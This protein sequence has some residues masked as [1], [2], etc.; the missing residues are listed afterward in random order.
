[1]SKQTAAEASDRLSGRL[2]LRPK[3]G[4][5]TARILRERVVSGMYGPGK[6][7]RIDELADS[8]GVSTMPVR[9]AL[10]TLAA[11][12]LVEGHPHRGF[13]V[14]AISENDVLDLFSV[15][16]F[17]ASEL[18]R[19]ATGL[20]SDSD[21][22][23]LRAIQREIERAAGSRTLSISSRLN[24]IEDKNFE[25]H[26]T[27]N[28]LVDARRLRWFLRTATRFIPRQFYEISGWLALTLSDH[29]PIILALEAKDRAVAAQLMSDHILAGGRLVAEKMRQTGF[30]ADNDAQPTIAT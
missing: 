18:A 25:F 19:R 30:W 12:G 29:P 22:A 14:G 6:R 28:R 16:A 3:I 20:I 2:S 24:L 27:I 9:E 10:I 17:C 1:M 5:E 21:V 11:E 4:D 13:K 26:A 7:L 15:H 23:R 8:I